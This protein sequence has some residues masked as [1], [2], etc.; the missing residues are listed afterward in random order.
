MTSAFA[1]DD[2]RDV[3][4]EL[5]RNAR[6]WRAE[7]LQSRREAAEATALAAE[8][9]AAAA[10]G[11]APTDEDFHPLRGRHREPARPSKRLPPRTAG[12]QRRPQRTAHERNRGQQ[13]E[14]RTKSTLLQYTRTP[15]E[16]CTM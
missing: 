4:A 15:T 9:G 1:R 5:S 8:V 16:S 10:I 2:A 12:R 3:E 11:D 7:V 6:E 14:K 13:R